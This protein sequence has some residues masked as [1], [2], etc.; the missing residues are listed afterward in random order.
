MPRARL[1]DGVDFGKHLVVAPVL[2]HA[3]V[4][5]HIDLVRAVFDRVRR[6]KDLDLRRGIA[7]READDRA[8]PHLVRSVLHIRLAA[9]D[10]ARRNA[11]RRRMILHGIVADA[12]NLLP[13]RFRLE[14]R[15]IDHRKNALDIH[16][17]SPPRFNSFII[18]HPQARG[19][20]S[21][22]FF[23]ALSYTVLITTSGRV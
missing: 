11:D 17:R 12:L 18:R 21:L 5:D 7:R 15:M 20:L 9:R 2:E 14:Q 19:K 10:I 8:Y 6:F 3:D 16:M 23:R 13:R 22:F 1:F 4:D